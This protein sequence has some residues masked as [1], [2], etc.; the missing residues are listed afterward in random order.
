MAIFSETA[1][2]SAKEGLAQASV[3]KLLPKQYPGIFEIV[4]SQAQLDNLDH[5]EKI[6]IL[7]AIENASGFF[8]ETEDLDKALQ[9]FRAWQKKIGKIAYMSLTWNTENRFGGGALTKVGLKRDG[10]RLIELMSQ[11]KIPLDLSHASDYLAFDI[12]NYLE[13]T[14][15]SLPL[16]ASHSNMRAVADVPRNLPD[17]LVLEIVRRKGIIGLNFF[18]NFVGRE[19]PANF[20]KHFDHVLRLGGERHVCFGADFFHNDDL[21]DGYQK[22]PE[23]AFFPSYDNAGAYHKILDLWKQHLYPSEKALAYICYQN[24]VD[25]FKKNL[26]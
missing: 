11:W 6:G 10:Q 22:T 2:G 23:E 20:I 17:D 9:Q 25:F 18:R 12:L 5:S 21:P 8:E 24:F 1:I 3:F 15:L 7:P 19:S 4:H 16:L 13:K 14:G 26:F